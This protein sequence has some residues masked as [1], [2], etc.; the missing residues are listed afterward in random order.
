MPQ[1]WIIAYDIAET[2]RLRRLAKHLEGIGTRLQNSVFE[3]GPQAWHDGKLCPALCAHI[4]PDEDALSCYA[5]CA[6]CRQNSAWQGKAETPQTTP[7]T[8]PTN[9]MRKTPPLVAAQS[10]REMRLSPPA[11]WLI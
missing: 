7:K 3:C 9:T 10:L 8:T 5:Q 2:Q 4:Q 1:R 11:Y 6:A